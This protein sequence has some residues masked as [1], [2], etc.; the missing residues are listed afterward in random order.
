MCLCFNRI[1]LR[2]QVVHNYNMSAGK[3]VV[4]SLNARTKLS[5]HQKHDCAN[6]IIPEQTVPRKT[7]VK[8][9]SF[10]HQVYSDSDL[11]CFIF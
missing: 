5:R 2:A 3:T 9:G 11:V 8:T 10:G 1:F 6:K 4:N 7:R